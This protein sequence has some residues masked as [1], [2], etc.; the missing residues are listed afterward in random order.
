VSDLA[1]H[2]DGVEHIGQLKI[3]QELPAPH[4]QSRILAAKQRL[5][6]EQIVCPR[7]RPLS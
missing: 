5:T 3:G 7:H 1:A 2:K 4:Q 6:D